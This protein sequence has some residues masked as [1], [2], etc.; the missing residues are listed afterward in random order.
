MKRTTLCMLTMG[1]L[2]AGQ[3][4]TAQETQ[5]NETRVEAYA[6]Q[7]QDEGGA[8]GVATPLIIQTTE[9]NGNGVR[10]N[11]RVIAAP[12]GPGMMSFLGDGGNMFSFAMGAG[13]DFSML[14][15]PSVQ[16]DLELVGEQM[17]QIQAI[18]NDYSAKIRD[19]I[20]DISKG[21]F[22]P[23]RAK[24]LST[25]IKGMKAKQQEQ[26]N[27]IL[28]PHQQDRIKQIALQMQM[29]SRGTAGALGNNKVAEALGI[30]D[31][32]KKRLKQREEE[33]KKELQ[34]KIAQ[35]KEDMK[36][37]LL[38]ELTTEQRAKLKD[39]TGDKFKAEAKDWENMLPKRIRDRMRRSSSSSSSSSDSSSDSNSS[40]SRSFQRRS[41]KSSSGG[42]GR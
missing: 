33:L 10:S 38:D 42:G 14:Q 7:V 17:K 27:K 37:S 19:A 39:M 20:G 28:L 32:Q 26:I 12:G 22:D 15:N 8:G 4:V 3:S 9:D 24:D 36:K 29:Q 23:E 35:F 31:E 18:Q 6:V 30:T 41:S 11:M 34:E 2:I 40:S 16:K 21:G 1:L 5:Q 25:V 13:D